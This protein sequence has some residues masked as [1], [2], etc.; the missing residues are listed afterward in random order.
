MP[1]VD[2]L[3][4]YVILFF[5]FIDYFNEMFYVQKCFWYRS[6]YII[7]SFQKVNPTAIPLMEI[8]RNVS[9]CNMGSS[10]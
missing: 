10:K 5:K 7:R 1:I 3:T 2:R 6:C 9:H 4:K 8:I